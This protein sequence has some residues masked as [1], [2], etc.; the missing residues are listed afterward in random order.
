MSNRVVIFDFD[1]TLADTGPIIHKLYSEIALKNGL[2]PMTKQDYLSLRK[3]T[4]KDARRWIGIK[5]WQFPLIVRSI[6]KLMYVQ[7][8]EVKLFPQMI[9]IVEQLHAQDVKMYIL[10]SNTSDTIQKVLVRHGLD[11]YFEILPLRRRLLGGK[12]PAIK[13]LVK[14]HNVSRRSIFMVG[15]EVRDIRAAKQA[16]V[17]SVAVNWG[18]QDE[19]ILKRYRPTH[20]VTSFSE[21]K[22]ILVNT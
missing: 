2:R 15:D 4:L 21:L 8:E 18:L 19:V 11:G 10:S 6:K 17:K 16:K 1:G 3:G 5:I 14:K 7:S 12:A 20:L 22:T 13:K 9:N